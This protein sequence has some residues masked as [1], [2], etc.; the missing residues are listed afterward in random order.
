MAMV[1]RQAI[2]HVRVLYPAHLLPHPNQ[3]LQNPHNQNTTHSVTPPSQFS[4]PAAGTTRAL[5]EPQRPMARARLPLLLLLL[6][7]FL[8]GTGSTAARHAAPASAPRAS[9]SISAAPEYGAPLPRL[10]NQRQRQRPS[11]LPPSQALAPDIM[12]VLPSPAEDGAAPPPDADEPTIPSSPSPPNPDALEPAWAL[13]PF[14]SAPA[15]AAQSPASAPAPAS[16][17]VLLAV[18]W[19]LLLVVV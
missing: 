2:Q 14:G 18:P 7:A 6:V 3:P 19:L 9:P 1:P 10:P 16:A 8:A 4:H 17:L 12:P 13:A 15:V 5:R 11:A